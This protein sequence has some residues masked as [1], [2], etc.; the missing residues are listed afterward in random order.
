MPATAEGG[1]CP[2]CDARLHARKPHA[3]S[4]TLALVIA[5]F[6]LYLPSNLFPMSVTWRLTKGVPHT[7]FSGVK[8]LFDAGLAPL[9]LLIFCTSIAIPMAKLIGLSWC[10]WSVY[11]R[12]TRHL[13][14]KTKL[15]RLV[16]EIGRWSN[17]D[18]FTIAVIAP[19]FQFPPL[20]SSHAAPG[21]V[22]F[23]AVVVMTMTASRVFDPRLMWDAAEAAHE[24]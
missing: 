8:D 18:P 16:D 4:A 20:V 13:V 21:A 1:L 5:G 6:L 15:C 22:A 24:R 12:S 7:I 14:F 11:R 19:L 2:R 9:G 10:M 23:I 3:M 17:I